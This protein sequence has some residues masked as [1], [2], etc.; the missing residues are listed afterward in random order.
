[1]GRTAKLDQYYDKLTKNAYTL[2]K[3]LFIFFLSIVLLLVGTVNIDDIN[4]NYKN[5][6]IRNGT[7]VEAVAVDFNGGS[8]TNKIISYIEIPVRYEYEGRTH[9]ETLIVLG[10]DNKNA[11]FKE[12]ADN[13]HI[14]ILVDPNDPKVISH[15]LSIKRAEENAP[16][17]PIYYAIA[18]VGGL[19]S[20]VLFILIVKTQNDRRKYYKILRAELRS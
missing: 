17:L 5:E 9:N 8:F 13:G 1:M 20:L 15:P 3:L 4:K 18:I 11:V 10:R 2:M 7:E 19:A 12:L 14:T 16:R 6:S